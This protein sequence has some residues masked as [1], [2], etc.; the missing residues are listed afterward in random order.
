MQTNQDMQ[1]V[2]HAVDRKHSAALVLYD[3]GDVFVD[4][5]LMS[6]GDEGLPAFHGENE[7]DDYLCIGVRHWAPPFCVFRPNHLAPLEE[8]EQATALS[9]TY[10]PAGAGGSGS[11]ASTSILPRWG[12]RIAV[13]RFYKHT[14]PLGAG[15]SPSRASTSILPRWGRGIGNSG[16]YKHAAPLGQADRRLGLLHQYCPA[17]A[18]GS[19]PRASTNILPRWGQ[20]DRRLGLLHQ[21]C[22]AG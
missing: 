10:C 22:P 16:F 5:F 21:Y 20:G 14:A 11:R 18:D 6:R 7:L 1:V 13:P 17:G 9:Q 8:G 15:G 3:A 4:L 12:R 2:W 19:G